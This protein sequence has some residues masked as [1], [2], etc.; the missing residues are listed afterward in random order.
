[1][2]RFYFDAHN[3]VLVRDEQGRDLADV[4]AAQREAVRVAADFASDPDRLIDEGV[5]VVS[6]RDEA[7]AV[8]T[9]VRLVCLVE[10]A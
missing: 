6:V 7:D 8:V 5:M 4:T 3:G 9:T 10:A 1:M 2:P